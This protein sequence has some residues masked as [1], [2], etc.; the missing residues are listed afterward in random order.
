MRPLHVALHFYLHAHLFEH[1]LQRRQFRHHPIVLPR[2]LDRKCPH[3]LQI[4]FVPLHHQPHPRH[5]DLHPA[6]HP[7]HARRDRTALPDRDGHHHRRHRRRAHRPRRH[8]PQLG[9]PSHRRHHP[10]S[11]NGNNACPVS[12]AHASGIASGRNCITHNPSLV[13]PTCTT[14]ASK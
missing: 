12:A 3:L 8:P 4:R 7:V 6:Q 13:Y 9:Q 2:H 11:V 5:A 14:P 1:H 10:C